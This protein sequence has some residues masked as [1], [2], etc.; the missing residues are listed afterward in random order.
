MPTV[1]KFKQSVARLFWGREHSFFQTCGEVPE[2][3][4]VQTAA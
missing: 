3:L 4:L 2:Q 1:G